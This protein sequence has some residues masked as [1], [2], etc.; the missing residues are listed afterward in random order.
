MIYVS[1]K[2][3]G[4]PE[5]KFWE[6]TPRKFYT[7]MQAAVKHHQEGQKQ[8]KQSPKG[9]PKSPGKQILTLDDVPGWN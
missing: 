8:S 7:M 9:T 6:E 5:D 4:W 2:E 3:L 1:Y